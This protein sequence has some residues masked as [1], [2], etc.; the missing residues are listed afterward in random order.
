MPYGSEMRRWR[1]GLMM[2]RAEKNK[3]KMITAYHAYKDYDRMLGKQYKYAAYGS[4]W[5]PKYGPPEP[6]YAW[7]SGTNVGFPKQRDAH[8]R[9]RRILYLENKKKQYQ[10]LGS[11]LK[12]QYEEDL[13]KDITELNR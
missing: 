5:K 7:F 2:R 13:I 8:V 1:Y 12:R 9:T 3:A 6:W 11:Y 4:N 10:K